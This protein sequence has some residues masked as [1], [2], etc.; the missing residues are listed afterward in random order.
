MKDSLDKEGMTFITK[1]LQSVKKDKTLTA[2]LPQIQSKFFGNILDPTLKDKEAS[3][4]TKVA[5]IEKLGAVLPS[6]SREEFFVHFEKCLKRELTRPAKK[7][8]KSSIGL[9]SGGNSS[10]I[11]KGSKQDS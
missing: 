2:C 9:N 6:H 5:C 11:V 4:P 3:Y 7:A 10:S 8:K 1:V